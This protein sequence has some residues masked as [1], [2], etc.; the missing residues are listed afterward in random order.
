MEASLRAS[1]ATELHRALDSVVDIAA[2][3]MASGGRRVR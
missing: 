2:D 3:R 1:R